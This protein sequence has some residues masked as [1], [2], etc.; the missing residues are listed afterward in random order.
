MEH[1]IPKLLQITGLHP[2]YGYTVIYSVYCV[3]LSHSSASWWARLLCAAHV[4]PEQYC[5]EHWG[6]DASAQ[7]FH[8]L[9]IYIQ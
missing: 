7:R 9:W 1:R 8:F 6:V 3:F 5:I 2:F 4:Y